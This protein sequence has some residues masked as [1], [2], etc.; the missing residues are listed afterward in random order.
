MAPLGRIEDMCKVSTSLYHIELNGLIV[1]IFLFFVVLTA[2]TGCENLVRYDNDL[3]IRKNQKNARKVPQADN[4]RWS[5]IPESDSL[6]RAKYE[7]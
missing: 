3:I 6:M 4:M 2:L 5:I 7:E 1:W